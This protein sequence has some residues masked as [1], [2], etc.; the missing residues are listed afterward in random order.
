MLLPGGAGEH[1]ADDLRLEA[2]MWGLLLPPP[3]P[4]PPT[5]WLWAGSSFPVLRA[6]LYSTQ[7]FFRRQHTVDTSSS[8]SSSSRNHHTTQGFTSDAKFFYACLIWE[9]CI[10]IAN[11]T[12]PFA[13]ICCFSCHSVIMRS[14]CSKILLMC[15]LKMWSLK[16]SQ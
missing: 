12:T 6:P 5:C 7:P 11:T 14:F 1:R 8:T 16:V 2:A 4:G 3:S 9:F 13:N 15:L 10:V